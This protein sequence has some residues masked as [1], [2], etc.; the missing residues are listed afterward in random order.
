MPPLKF[1]CHLPLG[2]DTPWEGL[3]G[4]ASAA[5]EA[6]FDA[7]SV[8]DHLVAHN[9][10][11]IDYENPAE[12]EGWTVLS[13]LAAKTDR[14]AL[15]SNVSPIPLHNPVRLAKMVTT[16]DVISGGR[17]V[18]GIGS[19]YIREEFESFGYPWHES[20]ER[21]DMM[22]EG[23]DVMIRLWTER[24]ASYN[25]KYFHLDKAL[26][27]PKSVQKP[28]PPLWFG[29]NSPSMLR[30]IA[31]VGSG[32]TYVTPLTYHEEK[33]YER[34]LKVQPSLED[35]E[36]LATSLRGYIRSSGRSEDEVM[37]APCLT[38]WPDAD[39]SRSNWLKVT[40]DFRERGETTW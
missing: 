37:F 21:M 7:V 29:G 35:F 34:S 22:R 23:V 31:R 13:A 10:N 20:A 11:I 27:F 3:V 30:E 12:L 26:F 18:L 4:M 38:Y 36:R 1:A 28:H 19:G 25:G 17:A 14:V 6:G 39:N 32:W 5:E 15:I 24:A 2:R 16:V 33:V 9:Y 8:G 40:D